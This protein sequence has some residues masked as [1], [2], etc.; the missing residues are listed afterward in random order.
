MK[1]AEIDK[2]HLECIEF[3]KQLFTTFN[4]DVDL[5]ISF[6]EGDIFPEFDNLM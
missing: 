4:K 5:L 6:G 1:K 3:Q 2:D